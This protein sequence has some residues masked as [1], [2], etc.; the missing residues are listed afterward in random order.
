D[1]RDG[2]D[3]KDVSIYEIYE[4]AKTVEGNENLT[5]DEFLQKYLNYTNDE[6]NDLFGKRATINRS[7]LTGCSIVTKASTV[8][9]GSG[10]FLWVD[11]DAGDA[12]VVTNC[13]VVYDEK[14]YTFAEEVTLFLYGQ[15]TN[16]INFDVDT[17]NYDVDTK[18]AIPVEIIGA[19]VTYDIA[20][21]KV[22]G[23]DV[24][25]H[26]N[27]ICASFTEEDDVHVG[28]FVYAI[29]N[30]CGEGVSAAEGIISRDSESVEVKVAGSTQS[31]R[32]LRTT[33]PINHGNSGGGLFNAYGELV[34]IVNAK[35]DDSNV[36]NM[37]YAI[38]AGCVKRLLKLMYD[39]YV[40]NGYRMTAGG[41]VHKARLNITATISDSFA[42]YNETTGLADI[43]EK[44]EISSV[45]G[46]PGAVNLKAGDIIKNIKI[47][48]SG[49]TVKEDVKIDRRH[50]VNDAL[51]SVRRG[52][53]VRVTVSRVLPLNDETIDLDVVIE[54]DSSSYFAYF[55]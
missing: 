12:Y 52:D 41:G 18:Y 1:G 9:F 25:K 2:L 20:L 11:K 46:M 29:G 3:G 27:I 33:A 23:S 32:V 28:E 48:S 15:D 55:N 24:I 10:I 51:F 35:D 22:T 45:D 44:V 37:G 53:T 5:L 50:K 8:A 19:S 17:Y 54:Y 47:I 42:V 7:L 40:S 38:P 39:E 31:Y 49:G 26:S 16:G 30:A 13:H 36:D 6:L 14:K 34:A 21:L 4:A 43:Y